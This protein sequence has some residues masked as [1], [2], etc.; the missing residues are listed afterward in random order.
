MRNANLTS[1]WIWDQTGQKFGAARRLSQLAL[2]IDTL[3]KLIERPDA[4]ADERG[5]QMQ[6]LP[7][8]AR[9]H[10]LLAMIEISHGDPAK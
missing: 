6:R 10:G 7:Q 1:G 4:E 5:L 8:H 9:L 3:G 2:A